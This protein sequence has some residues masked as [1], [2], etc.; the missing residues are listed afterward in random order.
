MRQAEKA[1]KNFWTRIPFILNPVKKIS[2]NIEKKIK[3]LKKP[4]SGI[5]NSQNGMRQV[6][7]E[8]KH[9][10]PEF[11][12]YST[13]ARKFPKKQKK[14]KLKKLFLAFFQ[15]K[16]DE[17]G[18]ENEKKFLVPNSVHTRH[19]H[20]NSKELEKKIKKIKKPP[21]GVIFS[22]KGMRQAEKDR[23]KFQPRIPFILDPSKKLPKK[24]A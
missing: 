7:K 9:F 11:R 18:Q 12:S 20:E 1:R 2:T 3:K 23:K 24:I 5:F 13:R 16:R 14:K 8:K 19:G 22:Q 4:L 10:S 6:E 17:I 15:Q 21:S